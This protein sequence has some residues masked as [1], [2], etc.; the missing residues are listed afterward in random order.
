MDILL[1]DDDA[2]LRSLLAE[3]F[4]DEGYLVECAADG[5]EALAQ[6][7]SGQM[8][9]QLI[10]LDLLMPLMP[11]WQF[12][13]KQCATPGLA[14]IPVVVMSASPMLADRLAPPPAAILPKPLDLDAL[15]LTVR[16]YCPRSR[17]N[18][19]FTESDGSPSRSAEPTQTPAEPAG[20]RSSGAD[21]QLTPAFLTQR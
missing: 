15:L 19:E 7:A 14:D 5:V 1:I 21:L 10:L 20:Q 6:L 11:G 4:A 8:L 9:P 17:T 3:F 16:R 2:N 12:R 18:N 13:A